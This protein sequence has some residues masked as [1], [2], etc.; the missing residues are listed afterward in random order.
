MCWVPGFYAQDDW[1]VLPRLTLNLGLRYEFM[2][3]MKETNG[4]GLGSEIGPLIEYS[5]TVL[6]LCL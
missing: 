4:R 1:R 3:V 2:T 6:I 5:S